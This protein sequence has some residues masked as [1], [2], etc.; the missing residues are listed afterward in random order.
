M[1]F[2]PS[3][4]NWAWKLKPQPTKIHI[5]RFANSN[6]KYIYLEMTWKNS[7]TPMDVSTVPIALPK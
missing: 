5:V 1:H 7:I 2:Q 4:S 3:S 6:F